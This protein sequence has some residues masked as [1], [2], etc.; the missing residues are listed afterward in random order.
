MTPAV[1]AIR[2]EADAKADRRRY[3]RHVYVRRLQVG[4][5]LLPAAAL[6]VLGEAEVAFGAT[7]S[8]RWLVAVLTAS[9]TVPLVLRRRAPLLVLIWTLANTIALSEQAEDFSQGTVPLALGLATYSA[10]REMEPSRAWIG[11]ALLFSLFALSAIVTGANTNDLAIGLLIYGGTWAAGRALRTRAAR[12]ATLTEQAERL[13]RDHAERERA[14]ITAERA[15]MAR[16]LH[17]IVS[18]AI[19]VVVLQT[20][21]VRRRLDPEQDA[22]RAD[23]AAVEATARQAM[24]EMRRLFGVLRA[25]GSRASL[26]PQPGLAQL[27]RLLEETRSAGIPVERRLE[28]KPVALPPG[29]DL[30]AFRIVQ[31]AL[32]NIRRHAGD[33]RAQVTVRFGERDLELL[34][35]DDGRSA[36]AD[37]RSPGYG[38]IGMR[39]RVAL[40]GG[41]LE[42]GRGNGGGF[43]IW[44][45]LPIREPS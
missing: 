29:V 18:H 1:A 27:D 39:E 5:D 11:L 16:E 33:A 26:E 37:E 41:S 13:E 31:E 23:L 32:T 6:L 12:V 21:A 38:L 36:S 2:L 42:T 9:L 14:A 20:R 3:G 22:E 43:R 25:D 8:P 34:V 35:E 4:A 7:S 15:R 24:A 44:A 19:S 28:G 10:G 40:Y 45:R 30:A 17:D